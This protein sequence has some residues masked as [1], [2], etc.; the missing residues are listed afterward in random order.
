MK[1]WWQPDAQRSASRPGSQRL[2]HQG[3]AGAF[4]VAPSEGS[5][6]E[7]GRLA[8]RKL[9]QDLL[10]RSKRPNYRG[11][12]PFSLLFSVLLNS[13]FFSPHE[14]S[15]SSASSLCLGVSVVKF[16]AASPLCASVFHSF[17]FAGPGG[18]SA[19]HL[20]SGCR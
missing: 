11:F 12:S 1:P 6:C 17:C 20:A 14:E 3:R 19:S 7:P 8:L 16:F 4:S 10:R 13:E 2:N 5:L 9:L 18:L 15:A